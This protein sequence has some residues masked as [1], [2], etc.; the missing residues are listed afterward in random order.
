ML[1]EIKQKGCFVALDVSRLR[2]PI[3]KRKFIQKIHKSAITSVAKDFGFSLQDK[4]GIELL[5]FTFLQAL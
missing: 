1:C 5:N 4:P 2:S 3:I